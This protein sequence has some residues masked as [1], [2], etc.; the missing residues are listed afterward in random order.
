MKD[1]T[2]DRMAVE[3]TELIDMRTHLTVAMLASS[4][5]VR[6]TRH[7]PGAPHLQ[8]YLD[9]S[10]QSLVEDVE[11]VDALVTRV[12]EEQRATTR[13]LPFRWLGFAKGIGA[14]LL[15]ALGGCRKR[16]DHRRSLRL[17]ALYLMH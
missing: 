12:T 4:Q 11:R 2:T 13:R 8:G 7:I 1:T 17:I 16:L 5:L 3:H 15:Y 6:K 10:L 9:Q 14:L